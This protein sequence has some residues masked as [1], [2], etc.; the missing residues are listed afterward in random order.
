LILPFDDG[1][2]VDDPALA[3]PGLVVPLEQADTSRPTT[4]SPAASGPARQGGLILL[5]MGVSVPKALSSI[6]PPGGTARPRLS[7]LVV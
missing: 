7:D 2:V 5:G 1:A 6:S 4:I 3:T